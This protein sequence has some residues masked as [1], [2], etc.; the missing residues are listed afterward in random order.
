[1]FSEELIEKLKE[2]EINGRYCITISVVKEEKKQKNNAS[3][4]DCDH[5]WNYSRFPKDQVVHCLDH[6]I[7]KEQEKQGTRMED[8]WH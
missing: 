6:I 3:D 2:A 1:M 8:N 7:Q 5:Y 4:F